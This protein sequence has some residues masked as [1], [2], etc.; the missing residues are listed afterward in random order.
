MEVY[1]AIELVIAFVAGINLPVIFMVY[2]RL[3]QIRDAI[4]INNG[5]LMRL[6]EWRAGHD[7]WAR[8]QKERIDSIEERCMGVL[9]REGHLKK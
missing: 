2:H 1:S 6:E 5:R 9:I 4:G 7:V 8:E 3:G